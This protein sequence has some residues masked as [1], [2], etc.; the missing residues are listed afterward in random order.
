MSNVHV[1]GSTGEA[2]DHSQFREDI[3]SGD[4]L[5]VPSEG[6]A[7]WLEQAWPIAATDQVGEFHTM[8]EGESIAA[9]V[10][11]PKAVERMNHKA[12]EACEAF[13]KHQDA[14]RAAKLE[15][16]AYTRNGLYD[17]LRDGYATNQPYTA[18]HLIR[19]AATGIMPA[20]DLNAAQAAGIAARRERQQ[21]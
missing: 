8:T 1:F 11:G 5:L 2:Y 17:A 7:G 9:D 10:Y 3:K 13:R 14:E 16:E 6:V 4:I 12:F 20:S 18:I 21:R 19:V 15:D